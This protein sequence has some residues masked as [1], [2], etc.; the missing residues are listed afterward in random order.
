MEIIG[1]IC[2]YNP[3]H[4]G[5]VSQMAR[6]RAA[7][8]EDSVLVCLMSGNYVQ[9]GQPALFDKMT[10]AKAALACGADLVLE[11]PVTRALSSAEGF[12]EGGVEILSKL[13]TRLS[14]GAENARREALLQ[15]AQALLS[16]A[17]PE[18]LRAALDTGCSFAAARQIALESMGIPAEIIRTPNNILGVEYCKAILRQGSSL[19]PEPIFRPGDYHAPEPDPQAPSADAIRRLLTRGASADA[20]FPAPAR[21]IFRD[22]PQ[23]RLSAGERAVLA[24]LR[25]MTEEDFQALPYGSEG[26][27]RKLMHAARQESSLEGIFAAVKSK[28]YAYTRISRMVMCAY[29]GITQDI[30][31]QSVP[32]ARVLGFTPAGRAVLKS[33]KRSMCL[34]NAGEDVPAPWQERETAWTDLYQLFRTDTP[35]KPGEEKRVRVILQPSERSFFD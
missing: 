28:R 22:A 17:Y 27:W 25:A 19:I 1:I 7:L 34:P 13:C 23:Y 8:E 2:E 3:L 4:L 33:G 6:I 15:A 35:G 18:K 10:R 26:L 30:L 11:L 29:L 24:R 21:P 9:R 14:F 5:H 31:A 20:Y 16:P 32:Y 12:A